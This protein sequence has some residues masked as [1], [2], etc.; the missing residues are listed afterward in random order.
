MRI[1]II[2]VNL[3]QVLPMPSFGSQ[4]ARNIRAYREP[5]EEQLDNF[6]FPTSGSVILALAY[7]VVKKPSGVSAG[8][9]KTNLYIPK[10]KLVSRHV[11]QRIDNVQTELVIKAV[12]VWL[13]HL[14][15]LN[16]ISICRNALSPTL[17]QMFK[18]GEDAK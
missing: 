18:R 16:R 15:W 8:L 9:A 13:D 4:L 1:K 12:F 5:L 6:V 14:A 10:A 7:L 11:H 2:P 3:G 17:N